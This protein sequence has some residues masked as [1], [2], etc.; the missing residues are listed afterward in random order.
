[1]KKIVYLLILFSLPA[2]SQ[3]ST[4]VTI[5]AQARD[6]EYIG[7][8]SFIDNQLENIYDSIKV[9]YRVPN[10]PANATT[11]V[12]V[13]GYTVDWLEVMRRLKNDATAV[14]SGSTGRV[15]VLLRAV[16]QPFLT[17]AIDQMDTSDI[18]TFTTQRLFGR[19]KLRRL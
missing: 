1:M 2:F 17:A 6:L 8:F 5:T 13:T 10:P 12:S 9:K 19:Q 4:K 15:E 11:Q 16:N 14:K 7:S 3:D 18:L